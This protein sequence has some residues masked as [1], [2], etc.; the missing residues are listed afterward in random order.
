MPS[1]SINHELSLIIAMPR[2]KLCERW[3]ELLGCDPPKGISTRLLRRAVVYEAQARDRGGL[4]KKSIKRLLQY[5]AQPVDHQ[6]DQQTAAK[7]NRQLREGARLIREWN[8]VNHVVDVLAD[9]F[10]WRGRT[11]RSLSRIAR[12]ITGA[13]WSGPRF[14]GLTVKT[15]SA[16]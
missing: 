15:G 10:E 12:E 14:F 6:A 11:Y 4:R 3:L 1:H 2:E 5:A 13:H 9:G 8:G 16:S 7:T